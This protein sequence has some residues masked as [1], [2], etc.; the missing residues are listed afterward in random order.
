MLKV[1]IDTSSALFAGTSDATSIRFMSFDCSRGY[2]EPREFV[3]A[4]NPPGAEVKAGSSRVYTFADARLK[5][6]S[7]VKKFIL[8][9]RAKFWGHVFS[10][11]SMPLPLGIQVSNDWRVKRVRVYYN[12]ALVSDTNPSNS[13][14]KSVWLNRSAYF[15]TFPDP[16]TEVVGPHGLC[17]SA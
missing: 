17:A 7:F 9:K 1:V 2:P 5:D 6:V 8:E 13:E 16:N 10:G 4:L 12:G 14:A 11:S 3:Y 15:M